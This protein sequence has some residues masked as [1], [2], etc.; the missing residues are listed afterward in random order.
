MSRQCCVSSGEVSASGKKPGSQVLASTFHTIANTAAAQKK[1]SASHCTTGSHD[2]TRL[3]GRKYL[4]ISTKIFYP[5]NPNLLSST[6]RPTVRPARAP[7]RWPMK[8]VRLSGS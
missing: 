4:K 8:P 2:R 7:Q 1:I 6:N 5:K 3:A